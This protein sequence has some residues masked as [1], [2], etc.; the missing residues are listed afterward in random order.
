[1]KVLERLEP[2]FAPTTQKLGV[3]HRLTWEEALALSDPELLTLLGGHAP[4]REPSRT[5]APCCG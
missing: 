3:Q 5:R 4:S 1:L 2:A